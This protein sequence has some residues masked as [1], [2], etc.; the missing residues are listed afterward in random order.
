VLPAGTGHRLASA[1]DAFLVVG[2]YPQGRDWDVIR[3]DTT[4]TAEHEA[5]VKR[6][7]QLPLP[8]RD[9]IA[10]EHGPLRRLW[11]PE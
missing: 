11:S 10:G 6:I 7:A 3:A 5:A 9:P 2:A 8:E 4:G 1:S